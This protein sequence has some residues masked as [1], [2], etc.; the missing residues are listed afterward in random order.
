ML[1]VARWIRWMEREEGKETLINKK[2]SRPEGW[3]CK[4]VIPEGFEPP[5]FWAVTRGIIQL[6]YGTKPFDSQEWN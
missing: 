5:I 1:S 3:L 6:C 2:K 4:V